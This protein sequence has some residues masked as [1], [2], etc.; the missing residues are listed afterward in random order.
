[1]TTKP[2]HLKAAIQAAFREQKRWSVAPIDKDIY[3][4]IERERSDDRQHHRQTFRN[5]REARAFIWSKVI[6]AAT[7]GLI[8]S[9]GELDK[10]SN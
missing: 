2:E 9:G 7:A 10:S 4:V 8:R 6:E 1:L 3:S 5:D